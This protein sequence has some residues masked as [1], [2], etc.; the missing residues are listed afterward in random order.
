MAYD[1]WFALTCVASMPPLP[2][3]HVPRPRLSLPVSDDLQPVIHMPPPHP[4]RVCL[5]R[6]PPHP[7]D[8]LPQSRHLLLRPVLQTPLSE[9]TRCQWP[10][11]PLLFPAPPLRPCSSLFCDTGGG[12]GGEILEEA[13]SFSGQALLLSYPYP[14]GRGVQSWRQAPT[15]R[16]VHS[17]YPISNHTQC[18]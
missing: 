3:L 16:L 13:G 7:L 17:T 18:R 12:G 14:R 10:P 6:G 15:H 4:S 11:L 9:L 1:V 2:L 8:P 5:G